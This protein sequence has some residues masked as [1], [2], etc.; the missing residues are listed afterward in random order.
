MGKSHRDNAKAKRKI[1]Q[2][3]YDKKAERRKGIPRCN[4]C[5]TAC[6]P[7]KLKGGNCMK[8]LEKTN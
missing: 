6:R 3:A 8:C 7:Q 1:G 4:T 5:G 2:K